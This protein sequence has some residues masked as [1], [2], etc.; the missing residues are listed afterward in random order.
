[1]YPLRKLLTSY[2]V[3]VLMSV[4]S[5][6][7]GWGLERSASKVEDETG[8]RSILVGVKGN[9]NMLNYTVGGSLKVICEECFSLSI[10]DCL[11]CVDISSSM[12]PSDGKNTNWVSVSCEAK[13]FKTLNNRFGSRN[14]PRSRCYSWNRLLTLVFMTIVTSTSFTLRDQCQSQ[15]YH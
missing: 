9:C 10:R 4:K 13:T 1:M 12:S 8:E 3:W 6:Q 15:Y 14:I 2:S 11:S 5:S 7:K